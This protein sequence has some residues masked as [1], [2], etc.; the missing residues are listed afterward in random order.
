M[1]NNSTNLK[2]GRKPV[3]VEWPSDEFT[4][5]D[6]AKTM[7]GKLSRV[8]VHSKINAAVEKGSVKIVRKNE[9]KMGRP[10]FIY[11]KND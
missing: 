4:A 1:K 11:K 10:S 6:V 7:H 8:S 5:S 9:G 3:A 2:R